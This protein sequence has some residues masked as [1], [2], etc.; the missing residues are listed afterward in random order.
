M[1]CA[2]LGPTP[3]RQRSA[4][5]SSS[6]AVGDFI[7]FGQNGSFI[8]GGRPRPPVRAD[9]FSWTAASTLRTAS[10]IAAATR[11]SS[12]SLSSASKDESMWTRLTSYLQVIVTLT[13]PAPDC[14][15]TSTEASSSWSLRMFSCICWACFIK[16]AICAF[17]EMSPSLCRLDRGLDDGR[18]EILDQVANERIAGDCGGRSIARAVA[19]GFPNRHGQAH[20]LAEAFLQGPAKLLL[21][22]LFR[23]LLRSR[24]QVKLERFAVEAPELAR[25]GKLLRDAAEIERIG[26]LG[27]IAVERPPRSRLAIPRRCCRLRGL[28]SCRAAALRFAG[29]ARS[30][31]KGEHAK[32]GHREAG[33]LVR[34]KR[35]ALPAVNGDLIIELDFLRRQ[36][37][38]QSEKPLAQVSLR[39]D[40]LRRTLGESDAMQERA[41][42]LERAVEPDAAGSHVLGDRQH[43]GGIAAR[44]AF[45]DSVQE[46]VVDRAE[47]GAH[48]LLRDVSGA[49]RDRLIEERQ[50]VAHAPARALRQ[51][52]QR[53]GFGGNLLLSEY[54]LQVSRDRRRRHLLQVELQAARE[55][56]H[57][58][59][60]GIGRGKNELDVLG[61]LLQGLQHRIEGR[62]GEHMDFVDDVYLEP[63]AGRHVHRVLQELAH[64]VHFG[65]GRRVD[66]YQVD[67]AARVDFH[68]GRTLPARTGAD[69]RLAVQAFREDAGE[70]R[71]AHPAGSG[72]EVRVMQA[73]LIQRIA[74][75]LHDV[76]LPDQRL[77]CA[78]T[79]LAGENLVRHD[80]LLSILDTKQVAS[81]TP[82]TCSD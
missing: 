75:R 25:L 62:R 79:P 12:M 40:G 14:P 16:P 33:E 65:V 24:R 19:G 82:G 56:R 5:I 29:V 3:G 64:L 78:R 61:R 8:P 26:E 55:H 6:R 71:L 45:E 30:R 73:L 68:A 44:E 57:R 27:P 17:T 2:D 69:A 39:I 80:G 9:I 67:E 18:V 28:A 52:P 58:D 51:Q 48:G 7:A 47:H 76:F 36:R 32:E 22:A 15:S 70:R 74:Q 46:A 38:G 81:L 13:M 10:L 35:K 53:P 20:G 77:E 60:L 34:S 1:R 63:P 4:S 54:G 37:P 49:V 41:E 72:E 66:L 43:G 42:I 11:S 59:F 21:E 31:G 23:E 50:G